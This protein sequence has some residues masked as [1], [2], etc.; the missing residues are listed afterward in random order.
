MTALASDSCRAHAE[1][2]SLLPAEICLPRVCGG[3]EEDGVDEKKEES[4]VVE[5]D[6]RLGL[7]KCRVPRCVPL[8]FVFRQV[9][10]HRDELGV[11]EYQVGAAT[12][13]ET[14]LRFASRADG[15]R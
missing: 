15:A 13:E 10:A 4:V 5:D 11:E 3:D 7:M 6:A 14:F 12:L 2:S 9:E 1:S 8:S